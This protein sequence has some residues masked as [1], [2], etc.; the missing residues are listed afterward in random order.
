MDLFTALKTVARNYATF[1]G[2]ATRAEFWWWVVFWV[3]A[4]SALNVIDGAVFGGPMWRSFDGLWTFAFGIG[5]WP[6]FGGGE[7]H[8]VLCSL[9]FLVTVLPW[10]ALC[11][12]RLRDAGIAV[13]HVYWNLLPGLGQII[14]CILAV[15]R[16][17]HAPAPP[18]GYGYP[19]GGQEYAGQYYPYP[20][21][22]GAGSMT[23]QPPAQAP[24]PAPDQGAPLP[25]PPPPVR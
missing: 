15:E 20:Y 17:A 21:P 25:P 6:P 18:P 5:R 3:L 14:V 22:P 16:S 11:T 7:N 2:R 13:G 4:S 1:Q 24:F 23:G 12:R 8:S 9:W 19:T 10:L